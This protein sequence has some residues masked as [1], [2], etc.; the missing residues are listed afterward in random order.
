MEDNL[1]RMISSNVLKIA[2]LWNDLVD[3]YIDKPSDLLVCC[4]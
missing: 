2:L 3:K 1:C 4:L